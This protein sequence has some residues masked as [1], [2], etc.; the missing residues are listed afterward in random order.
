MRDP[1]LFH[2]AAP[3]VILT[4]AIFPLAALNA[5]HTIYVNMDTCPKLSVYP[6]SFIAA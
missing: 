2:G 6:A 3:V 4:T 5:W 1:I